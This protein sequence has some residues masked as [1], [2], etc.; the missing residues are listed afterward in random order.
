[1][2]T[3]R[4]TARKQRLVRVGKLL[5]AFIERDTA[6]T[7]LLAKLLCV[8]VRTVQRDLKAL[9]EAGIPI[10]E[11]KKGVYSLKKDLVRYGDLSVF[12]ESELAL[13]VA[14]KDLVSQLGAPFERAAEDILGR[15]C[16]YGSCRP[17]YVK[18]E[19]GTG[20][21]TATMNRLVDA[22]QLGRR[23]S[24]HYAGAKPHDV[25]AHPYRVAYFN[26][27]WYLVAKDARD[28]KIKKYAL[29]RVSGLKKLRSPAGRMPRDLDEALSSSV[30]VW[31][32]KDRTIEVVVEVDSSWAHYF[33]RRSILPVQEIVEEA[34]DG[35]LVIRFLACTK[36][37]VVMCLKPWLPH[38][39]V[40][41]PAEIASL[42]AGELRSWLAWQEEAM[43]RGMP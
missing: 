37:E 6:G 16:E 35:S 17:V 28:G 40:I 2:G 26:G 38:L 15:V 41:R 30:N 27:F 32:E 8:D 24:F 43:A 29:N 1:V 10:H 13:I 36:E 23:V 5:R 19:S 18:V 25:E 7:A 21:S 14:I 20:L 11:E 34:P 33:R 9:R 22:I 4:N 31:F 39:R 12:D 42:I 3:D